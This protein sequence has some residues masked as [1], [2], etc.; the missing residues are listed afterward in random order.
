MD[1]RSIQVAKS[2]ELNDQ[3]DIK[4]NVEEDKEGFEDDFQIFVTCNEK[5]SHDIHRVLEVLG[6]RT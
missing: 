2:T 5:A 3:L 6:E 1:L 4:L